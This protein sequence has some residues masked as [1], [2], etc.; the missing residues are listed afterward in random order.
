MQGLRISRIV[1]SDFA[2]WWAPNSDDRGQ[3]VATD[4]SHRFSELMSRQV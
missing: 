1:G 3:P 2:G 4:G